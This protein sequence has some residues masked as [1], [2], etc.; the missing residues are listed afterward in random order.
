VLLFGPTAFATLQA[1]FQ[2]NFASLPGV[3][4]GDIFSGTC[5]TPQQMGANLKAFPVITLSIQVLLRMLC[6]C[7]CVLCVYV[8]YVCASACFFCCWHVL[9]AL[10]WC[11]L[12]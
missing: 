8:W 1:V 7:V 5:L 10:W 6:V 9:C 3:Q 12:W 4:A 2:T 11:W